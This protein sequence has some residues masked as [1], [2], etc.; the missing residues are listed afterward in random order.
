M[1]QHDLLKILCASYPNIFVIT[2]LLRDKKVM[3]EANRSHWS[4]VYELKAYEKKS[5]NVLAKEILNDY[6]TVE[7]STA[8]A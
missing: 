8:V 6:N 4:K 1:K 7:R 3:I 5:I 2:L